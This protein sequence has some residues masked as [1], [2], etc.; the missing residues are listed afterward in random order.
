MAFPTD[1]VVTNPGQVDNA[2]NARALFLKVFSGEVLT[3]FHQKNVAL[4]LTRTRT[5]KSGKSAQ[6]PVL[7]TGVAKYHTPGQLVTADQLPSVERTVTIDDVALAAIFVA[8]IDEAIS[9]YEVRGQYSAENGQTLADLIDRNI[10]RM[11]AQAAFITDA[12]AAG[13]AGLQVPSAGQKYTANI[14]LAS[15]GDENDGVKIVNALFKAR[16]QFRKNSITGELVCVLPPEQYEALVN[17]QD[18]NKV[19]WMNK[20]VGGVGSAAAGVIPYVAGIKIIESVNVP[21]VDE[22]AGLVGDPEPLADANVGSGNQAKYRGDYSKVVG[23]VFHKDAV[24]TTKLMDV[25]TKWVDE[26]LRLGSTVLTTQAVG[27]DILRFECAV[28]IL[29]V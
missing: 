19:T 24:A 7:G 14:Q 6:F 4:G 12:T 13:N 2:G 8:D 9:H 20:D 25:S 16:T 18:A 28:A 23:L 21:Q 17:V 11:V 27:H 5:I 29:K 26:E 3:A 1:Q 15:A 22:T 10:F